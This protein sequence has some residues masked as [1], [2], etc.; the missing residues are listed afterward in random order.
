[1]S[2]CRPD[3]DMHTYNL[4]SNHTEFLK[5]LFFIYLLAV[6]GTACAVFHRGMQAPEHAGSVA[7]AQG[8]CC[9]AACGVLV[10]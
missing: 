7:T 5:L 8:L 9:S 10:P 1:M 2:P 4:Y 3:P 6:L